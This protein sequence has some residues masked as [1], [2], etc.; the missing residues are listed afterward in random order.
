MDFLSLD[1]KEEILERIILRRSEFVTS[2]ISGN[3]VHYRRSLAMPA[4][5]DT[6]ALFSRRIAEHWPLLASIA[7]DRTR[8]NP[9]EL[10]CQ[11]TAHTDLC[12]FHVH[13]DNGSDAVRCRALSYVYYLRLRPGSFFGGELKIYPDRKRLDEVILIRPIDNSAFF[14]RS[15]LLHEVIPTY[16]PSG[17]FE[18]S[19]FTVNGWIAG[20]AM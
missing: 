9:Q 1:E 12:H 2:A 20:S 19:R 7:G 11:I 13:S 17:A 5:A 10:E 8:L 3:T 4:D 14:F 6:R 15:E 18:D 16:V